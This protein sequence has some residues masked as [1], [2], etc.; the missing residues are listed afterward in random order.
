MYLFIEYI[1]RLS[2]HLQLAQVQH[3]EAG[4]GESKESSSHRRFASK[5]HQTIDLNSSIL[6]HA[7]LVV[8]LHFKGVSSQHVTHSNL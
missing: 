3:G 4:N 8:I 6:G 5:R 2:V 1:T 7:Q